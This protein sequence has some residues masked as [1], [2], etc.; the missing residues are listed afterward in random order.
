MERGSNMV[1]DGK[2]YCDFCGQFGIKDN[3]VCDNLWIYD[4]IT[5]FEFSGEVCVLCYWYLKHHRYDDGYGSWG[6]GY[7]A[8]LR[9]GIP[10]ENVL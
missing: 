5:G 4:W 7:M 3:V 10:K 6:Q 8:L 9:A 2:H 1:I